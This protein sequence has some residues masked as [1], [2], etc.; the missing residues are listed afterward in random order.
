MASFASTVLGLPPIAALVFGY[1]RGVYECVRS[2]F[3]EFATAVGFDAATDGRYHLCRHVA[4]R[5]TQPTS[6]V[7]T[8]S[9]RELFLF[10]E[11]DR[12]AR[13]VLHLAIYEG[14]AAA[15]E[16]ILACADLFSDNAIDMAVFYNLSLI[17][18]HLLQ[19]RAILMQRGRA[20]SWRSATTVRSSKL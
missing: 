18:S 8:L 7:S 15:V 1:Q 4:S 10:S 11:T 14:D 17:A 3:V 6:S 19:H 13:F 2:R 20:L 12:E 5:L 9:V 16:R